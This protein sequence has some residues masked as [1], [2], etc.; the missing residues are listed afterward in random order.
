MEAGEG[1][2][3]VEQRSQLSPISGR[4]EKMGAAESDLESFFEEKKRI[5]NPLVPIGIVF[6]L[7]FGFCLCF[8]VVIGVGVCVIARVH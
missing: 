1:G 8:F 4:M 7:D 6:R 5:R 3:V 2:S